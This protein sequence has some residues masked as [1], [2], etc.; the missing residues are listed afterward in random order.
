MFGKHIE[1][2]KVMCEISDMVLTLKG[3]SGYMLFVQWKCG[4]KSGKTERCVCKEGRVDFGGF[5]FDD[6]IQR[7][8]KKYTYLKKPLMLSLMNVLK[9]KNSLVG[10]I[11][12]DLSKY[13]DSSEDNEVELPISNGKL[14]FHLITQTDA[15]VIQGTEKLENSEDVIAQIEQLNEDIQGQLEEEKVLTDKLNEMATEVSFMKQN[16]V[17]EGDITQ[18]ESEFILAEIFLSNMSFSDK[19][20]PLTAETIFEKLSEGRLVKSEKTKFLNKVV[21]VLEK[22][23]VMSLETPTR[24]VYWLGVTTLLTKQVNNEI[25]PK[26]RSDK[27]A[28]KAFVK[29]LFEVLKKSILLVYNEIEPKIRENVIPFFTDMNKTR[30]AVSSFEPFKEYLDVMKKDHIPEI[31]VNYFI[32]LFI[33]R[34]DRVVFNHLM[35]QRS[36]KTDLAIFVK[37]QIA[38][39]CEMIRKFS[40]EMFETYFTLLQSFCVMSIVSLDTVTALDL[41]TSVCPALS[42]KQ[43]FDIIAKFEPP[44]NIVSVNKIKNGMRGIEDKQNAVTDENEHAE[45]IASDL[46][47]S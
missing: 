37:C 12:V 3:V 6:T 47:N 32:R 26:N 33:D 25:I 10:K 19:H 27:E 34:F 31:V 39:F 45:L 23:S 7:D 11:E 40:T 30:G 2:W 44:V 16:R 9:S 13:M 42:F 14:K 21:E 22:I 43:I 20:H 8:A 38:S 41:S 5:T 4:E 46:F 36:V 1:T 17:A 29:N 18:E 24:N 35:S 28:H 15:T